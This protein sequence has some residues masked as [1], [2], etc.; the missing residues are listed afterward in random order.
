VTKIA[1]NDCSM[2]GQN[3]GI[4]AQMMASWT[5]MQERTT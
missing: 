5:S 2:I 3:I 1:F 4:E